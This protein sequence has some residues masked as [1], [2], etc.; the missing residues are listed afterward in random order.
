M[1]TRDLLYCIVI[2]QFYQVALT[3]SVWIMNNICKTK[4][5]STTFVSLCVCVLY[6]FNGFFDHLAIHLERQLV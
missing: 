2:F 6:E 4:E 1:A 3:Y 5:R